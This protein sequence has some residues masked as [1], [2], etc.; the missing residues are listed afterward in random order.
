MVN[1]L[2]MQDIR[3]INLFSNITKVRT[4]YCFFYNDSI[5]F[6]VPYSSIFKA[7]GENGA[8]VKVIA[9][10]VK[11]NIKIVGIPESSGDIQNFILEVVKPITLKNIE[12]SGNEIIIT[13]NKQEKAALIGRNKVRL[14]ELKN[15][16]EK[17]FE[18]QLKIF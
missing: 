18:K 5:I 12:I 3:Y 11:R 1:V 8:N 6:A 7:V 10:I 15:I 16:V 9:Q 13:A 14:E 4:R 17:S 2:D